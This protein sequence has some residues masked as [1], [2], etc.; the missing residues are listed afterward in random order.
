MIIGFTGTRRGLTLKQWQSVYKLLAKQIGYTEFHHGDCV[1]ADAD[2]H[3]MIQTYFDIATVIH[4]P[5][6]PKHR[7]FCEG[8]ALVA[9]PKP[10]LERNKDI[11][12]ACELLIACP[13]EEE[14]Q[15]RSGTWSTIRYARTQ[16]KD[17]YIFYP[18]GRESVTLMLP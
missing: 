6:N 2:V 13:G 11:V 5:D 12:N 17:I 15:L 8:T 18:S 1:G 10:Y 3:K 9:Q 16:N 4:P 7:A 14:E